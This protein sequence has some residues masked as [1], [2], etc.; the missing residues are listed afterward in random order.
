MK[1]KKKLITNILLLFITLTICFFLVEL[2]LNLV[3][4]DQELWQYDPVLG[5]IH[6]P[7]K[8]AY[9]CKQEFCH[10][11]TS[12][13]QGFIDEEFSKDKKEN[14]TRIFV[15]GD[16]F[17]EA[18]QVDISN[19]THTLLENNLN[20]KYDHKIDVYNLGV[21]NQGT[22][23]YLVALKEY[24]QLYNPDLVIFAIFPQ[25]DLRNI[26]PELEPDKCRPFFEIENNELNQIPFDCSPN[27]VEK[28]IRKFKT[29]RYIFKLMKIINQNTNLEKEGIPLDYFVYNPEDKDFQYSFELND[30]ILLEAKEYS[31]NIDAKFLVVILTTPIQIDEAILDNTKNINPTIEFNEEYPNQRI[32]EFCTKHNIDCL[33]LLP[34]F[35]E[36]YG[37]TK[38]NPHFD[39]DVHWNEH[40][41]KQASEKIS[42]YIIENNII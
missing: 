37:K 22:A 36:S 7:D 24:A 5:S 34:L 1:N 27:L 33:D 32:M 39:I 38:I 17:M 29:F 13:S 16:S 19:S 4:K 42:E 6:I 25:N 23:Q 2:T 30:K 11:F 28:F 3:I 20:K 12:N 35:K 8:T 40:G 41:H 9:W 31:K 21:S 10:Q 14:E 26:N 18:L 15:F